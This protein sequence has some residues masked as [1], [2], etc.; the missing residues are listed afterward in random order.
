MDNV[1]MIVPLGTSVAEI[2]GIDE[3]GH[4]FYKSSSKP[5][6]ACPEKLLSEVLNRL[7]HP[8]GL[9]PKAVKKIGFKEEHVTESLTFIDNLSGG[10]G[11]RLEHAKIFCSGTAF[12]SED[13]LNKHMDCALILHCDSKELQELPV[14]IQE[15]VWIYAYDK[16]VPG[17][18]PLPMLYMPQGQYV[19]DSDRRDKVMTKERF[20]RENSKRVV[21]N[22]SQK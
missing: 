14:N 1:D 18:D 9:S 8:G 3:F 16:P 2:G 22:E 15:K 4:H 12:V 11:F 21:G 10:Y 13:W 6:L 20:I 17:T 5:L 19:L 7:Q